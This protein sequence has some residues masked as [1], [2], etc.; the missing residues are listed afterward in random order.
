MWL[1]QDGAAPHFA[2]IVPQFL[3]N[4]Y[5]G[6][7]IGRGSSDSG[8]EWPPYPPDLTSPDF[9]LWGF[10]K[11]VVFAQRSTTRE[12]MMERTRTACASIPREILLRTVDSFERR[13]HLCLQANGGNFEQLLRG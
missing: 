9:F 10:V 11:N 1:Q 13:L 7:W 12:N 6:R 2:V 4:H 5:N 3:N 8:H